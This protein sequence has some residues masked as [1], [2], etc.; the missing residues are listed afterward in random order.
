MRAGGAWA[1]EG[2]KLEC[3]KVEADDCRCCAQH[4]LASQPDFCN[5]EAALQAALKEAGYLCIFLPKF[6]CGLN[7]IEYLWGA[8]AKY[9]RNRCAY[10]F[11]SLLRIVPKTLAS[12]PTLLVRKWERPM[13]RWVEAYVMDLPL[14]AGSQQ[15]LGGGSRASKVYTLHRH[16]PVDR[17]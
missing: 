14:T 13:W 9:C 15:V 4:F 7:I 2:W 10:Q 17:A 16:T 5:A 1:V 8:A 12:M 6:H 3:K 11:N